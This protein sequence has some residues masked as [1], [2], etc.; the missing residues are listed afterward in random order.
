VRGI[1]L[2]G[3]WDVLA[4]ISLGGMLGSLARYGLATAFPHGPAGFPWATFLTN[5]LGCMLIGV[6]MVLVTDVWPGRRLLR[7]FLG[8]GVLGGFT[9]FSTYGV[10]VWQLLDA[11]TVAT[12]FAYLAATL[13]GALL[14]VYAGTIG[15]RWL[16]SKRRRR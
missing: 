1:S 13:I 4:T 11:D 10:D 9:T 15:T 14:A 2:R 3:Q 16:L 12:A 5:V 7:P 8:V 6:L